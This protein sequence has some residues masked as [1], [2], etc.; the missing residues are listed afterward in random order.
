MT[1]ISDDFPLN[2]LF[3]YLFDTD[4]SSNF[5]IWQLWWLSFPLNSDKILTKTEIKLGKDE[6]WGESIYE[7]GEIGVA[8]YTFR[9]S[10]A[11]E[12]LFYRQYTIKSGLQ[13]TVFCKR[14]VRMKDFL[15]KTGILRG[16]FTKNV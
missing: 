14:W 16:P 6:F 13:I 2:I 1:T 9:M 3:F 11:K 10:G 5:M 15:Q 8:L 12:N 7:N 4:L